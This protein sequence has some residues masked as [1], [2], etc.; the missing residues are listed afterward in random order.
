MEMEILGQALVRVLGVY[1]DEITEDTT[2]MSDLG[3]DSLDMYQIVL[4]VEE[5]LQVSLSMEDVENIQTVG[6]AVRM[7]HQKKAN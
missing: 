6:E 4:E 5:K 7:L 1:P 3:A 2:F